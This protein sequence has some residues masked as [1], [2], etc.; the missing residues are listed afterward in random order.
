MECTFAPFDCLQLHCPDWLES[1]VLIGHYAA[2]LIRKFAN[3]YI[4]VQLLL[5]MEGL[6]PL[7][8]IDSRNSLLRIDSQQEHSAG[9]WQLSLWIFPEIQS[10]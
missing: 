4:G 5:D 3:L 10:A 7:T 8:E 1:C 9:G 2:T 6:S